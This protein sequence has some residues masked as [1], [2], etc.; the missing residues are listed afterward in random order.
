MYE[1]IRA[2]AHRFED[3]DLRNLVLACYD[4]YRKE[5]LLY[6]AAV[7]MHHAMRSGLL[8]HT[9]SI[10][11]MC[12]AAAAVYPSIDRD[13]LIAGAALHDL[14]KIVEMDAGKLGLASQYTT[15]GNL[16][17][18]LVRGAMMVEEVGR[19]IGTPEDKLLLIEHMLISHHGKPE[20]GA[21]IPPKFLEA[22]VL[23]KMDEL[24]AT[25]FEVESAVQ[26]LE[27]DT[28]TQPIRA[29]DFTRL[30]NPGRKEIRPTADLL[31]ETDQ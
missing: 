9:L 6:P 25:V 11:R 3:D 10:I 30:Y 7:S 8:Y 4:K 5:L 28:F 17:G 20:Y 31:E 16:I 27:P 22:V 1:E 2:I 19:D 18:H 26:G 21:A 29:M 14:G 24:D 23:S 12:E 15:D 13:L